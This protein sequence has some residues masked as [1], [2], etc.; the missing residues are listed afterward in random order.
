MTQGKKGKNFPVKKNPSKKDSFFNPTS[1]FLPRASNQRGVALI[2]VVVIMLTVALVGASLAEL[3]TTVNFSTD[4]VLNKTK[5]RYLAEAGIAHAMSLL[6]NE[7]GGPAK[8]EEKVGPIPLGDGTYTILFDF[9]ETTITSVGKCNGVRKK[10]QL[11][12]NLF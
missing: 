1:Y 5:A 7:S 2:S 12:Y 9:A 11:Q 6:R 4:N 8:L 3:I 10:L